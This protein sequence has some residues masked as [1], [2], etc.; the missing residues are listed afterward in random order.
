M[1][2]ATSIEA[3]VQQYL[4]AVKG[5]LAH[6]PLERQEALLRELRE[7]IHE[8]IIARTS[9]RTATLQDAYAT[10]SELDPPEA[11][12][13]SASTVSDEPRPSKKLI[14]LGLICSGLQIAGLGVAVAGIP[15]LGAIAGFAAIVS[16]F[17]IWSNKRSPKWLVR[18]TAVAAI[19]GLGTIA[20]EMARVL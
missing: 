1:N 10:L 8:A 17:L 20:I 2:N 7:H 3:V 9:G 5:H 6:T 4:D 11:Y 15:V 14:V 13:D 19:C 18:L 16:F 12:A